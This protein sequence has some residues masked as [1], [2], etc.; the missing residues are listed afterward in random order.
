MIVTALVL[1]PIIVGLLLY[2][3]P[4]N[5]AS[6][7]KAVAAVVGGLAFIAGLADPHASDASLHWLA[8]PFDASFH[9]GYGPISYWL[10]LLLSLVTFSAALS[11]GGQRVRDLAAQLL[12]LQGAMNGVF[13]TKDLL[14]FALF[15]DLML[16]P[17]FMVLIQT[18]MHPRAA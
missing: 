14:L 18:S 15:W 13:L 8:R 11:L 4:R 7:A 12:V 10:V 6:A 2:A 3:L 5:S 17:V 16:L 9:L 1:G